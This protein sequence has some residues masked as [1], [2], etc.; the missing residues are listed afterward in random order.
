VQRWEQ[1]LGRLLATLL[2]SARNPDAALAAE[3]A[4]VSR[5]QDE[6]EAAR[7]LIARLERK[8]FECARE[9]TSE[10]ISA[11]APLLFT[12]SK[13]NDEQQALVD[14]FHTFMYDITD[15]SSHRSYFVSWL[16][17]G[18][19]KWPTDLWNYQE[20]IV[21]TKP[22]VI[23]E[24]GTHRGGSALFL[25]SICDLID[26]GEV[27]SI[28][29]DDTYRATQPK[30]PRI[31]FLSGSST[32]PNIVAEIKRRIAGRT[33]VFVILDS[34]HHCNH[35][36]NELRIYSELIPINGYIVAEDTNV[37]GHPAYPEFGPGPRE[38]VD[39]FLGENSH[40]EVDR[41][42]ERF[43]LTQN[44]CGFLRRRSATKTS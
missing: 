38:A 9:R 11:G 2:P 36:L 12:P 22:D 6:I 16:G 20:I 25:A 33:N 7:R 34:D 41:T 19:F 10:R 18:M 28:D 43:Y 37:N 4:K 14:R 40:F 5:L 23:V 13:L 42:Q 29:I 44:P 1:T 27:I 24:T 26:K 32:D 39:L 3:R 15:E 30:H 8:H 21:Q 35:V 17:Y 31:T